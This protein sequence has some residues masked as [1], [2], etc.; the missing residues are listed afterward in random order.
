MGIG[1]AIIAANVIHKRLRPHVHQFGYKVYYLC[2]ALSQIKKL[3]NRFLSLERWNLLGFYRRDHADRNGG[4]LDV[5]I[6][7]LLAT[8][9]IAEANGEII[10]LALPRILGYVF[11]PVSFWFCLDQQ[12]GLR[13]VLSEVCNTFGEHHS[14]ISYHDDH[15]VIEPVDWLRSEK[16]FHVSPFM[17]VKGY[18]LFQFQCAEQKVSATVNYYDDQGL[19]LATSVA[20][21]PEILTTLRLLHYFF[22]YPLVTF[23]VIGLIHW[24]AVR[25]VLKGIRYRPKPPPPLHEVSR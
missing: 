22:R 13:A 3:G 11:N 9:K 24:E 14:Y 25:L 15:R 6:R 17:D 12:G 2:F 21:K 1:R 23:K 4:D 18:Y 5:W 16:L 7:T 10:L 8:H 20:G 19:L